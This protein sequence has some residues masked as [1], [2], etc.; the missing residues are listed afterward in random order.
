M[1]RR[2][3][4]GTGRLLLLVS[5]C[6]LVGLWGAAD[7]VALYTIG[8]A[9]SALALAAVLQLVL[10][11]PSGRLQT[12]LDRIVVAAGWTI[13]ILANTL[14]LIF[15]RHP[16]CA[17]C[18]TNALFTTESTTAVDVISTTANVVA[19]GVIGTAVVIVARRY[20]AATPV[21]R[22]LMRPIGF[23]GGIPLL[24]LTFGFAVQAFSDDVAT[25]FFV[26]GL[27]SLIGLPF[28]FLIGLLSSRLARGSVAQLLVDVRETTSLGDAQ[29]ALRR[30]LNDPGLRLA[31][32]MQERRCY[33]DADGRRFDVPADDIERVSTLVTTEDGSPVAAIVH[34]RA[35]LDEPE[36]V[37]G[38]V[39]AARLALQRNRLQSELAIR[40]DQLQR[41]R[42]FMRD[43]VNAAPAFFLV[44]DYDG[45]VIRFNDT[46]SQVSGIADDERVRGRYWWDVFVDEADA[47]EVSALTA[48]VSLER[49]H[50]RFRG[51]DGTI[52]ATWTLTPVSDSEGVPRLVLT[53]ADVSERVRQEEELRRERDFLAIVARSTPTL[54][55]TVDAD[56]IVTDRGVNAAFT[57]ATGIT[58][59]QA[60]GRPFWELVTAADQHEGMQSAF[61][62]S[63]L[64]GGAERFETPWRG[65]GGGEIVI[66][67]WV[68]S[69]DA[70]RPGNFLVTGNDVTKR[71]R[72]EDE[73]RQSRARLVEAADAE[74]RR[75]ERNL[76]DGAQQ[77]LVS[78]SLALRLTEQMLPKDPSTAAEILDAA[79]EELAL[80]LQEL[81]ELARG[82]HPAVL[83]DRGLDAALDALADR[84]PLPVDVRVE[85]EE[86]LP[87]PVE[88]AIY[89]V[90]AEAL[91][92]VAKYAEA[93]SATVRV[94]RSARTVT[95]EVSDDGVG[96]ASPEGGTGLRGL[97]DRVAALDGRLHVESR[98]GEGTRIMAAIPLAEVRVPVPNDAG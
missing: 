91:T 93:T 75:L 96:G 90:A 80:A 17:G 36:L 46:M 39:A 15:S 79:M 85:V 48:A 24:L 22:R 2:P 63:V 59:E 8:N 56:G 7:D 76:H 12:R 27:V 71:K 35:L 50:H 14:T 19:A 32:W 45:R 37:E 67:W 38:V 16:D 53:G 26:A 60:I 18:P 66:E 9:A 83:T 11:Y 43:V 94:L 29:E 65:A 40:L 78:L 44:I 64:W 10:A 13:A 73:V 1:A 23:A 58:D 97:E 69:L 61:A 42:D 5:V 6:W 88:V 70:Y 72:D 89:Y 41:E 4:N 21:A 86:R 51:R 20:R 33:L 25:A 87:M 68:T 47:A 62:D 3:D 95:V 31:A 57:S 77:R 28:W 84:A 82:L 92:N 55:C 74:R 81:R 54:M 34:D 98:P 30:A 52:V 49:H